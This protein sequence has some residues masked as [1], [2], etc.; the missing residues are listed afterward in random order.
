VARG[1]DIGQGFAHDE[2]LAEFKGQE[3]GFR[4]QEEKVQKIIFLDPDP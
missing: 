1:R 3:P 2:T 4:G